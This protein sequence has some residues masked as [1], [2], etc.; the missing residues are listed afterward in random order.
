MRRILMTLALIA[1]PGLGSG[2]A[3]AATLQV[4]VDGRLTGATGVDVSGTL[5][6]VAF[7]DGRCVDLFGGCDAPEDFPFPSGETASGEVPAD[8]EI[9]VALSALSSQVFRDTPEAAFDTDPTLTTGCS[10]AFCGVSIPYLRP[11]GTDGDPRR[12]VRTLRFVN[13]APGSTG[14]D[15][16][17]F[18]FVGFDADKDTAEFE[19]IT[20]AVF[21]PA[22]A[23]PETTPVPLPA[24][25]WML[26]AGVGA[27]GMARARTA[28]R[29]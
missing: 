21:T 4:D 17:R 26:L 29:A 11:F 8:A 20:F 14:F 16:D 12:E 3:V 18:G 5:Y 10:I 7:T 25:G 1:M 23:V 15:N 2:P 19:A 28:R 27:L 9:R 24:A 6:D 13:R 22:A